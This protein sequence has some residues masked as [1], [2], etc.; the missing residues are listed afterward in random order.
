MIGT[1]NLDYR[2]LYLHFENSIYLD[3][4]SSINAMSEHFR[5]L[6]DVSQGLDKDFKVSLPLRITQIFLRLFSYMM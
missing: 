5:V 4:S 6:R 3:Q 2:S 1:A